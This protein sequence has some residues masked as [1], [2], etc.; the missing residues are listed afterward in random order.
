[1]TPVELAIEHAE[2]KTDSRN[3]AGFQR[4]RRSLDRAGVDPDMSRTTVTRKRPV[5]LFV[6]TKVV[7]ALAA[8]RAVDFAITDLHGRLPSRLI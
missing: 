8:Q 3:R 5:A 2:G 7:G 6:G 4:D 1:M